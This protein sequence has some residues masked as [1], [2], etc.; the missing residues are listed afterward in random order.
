MKQLAE[1]EAVL[2]LDAV[3]RPGH[4]IGAAGR[5]E[6]VVVQL[7]SAERVENLDGVRDVERVGRRQVRVAEV[8]VAE[9]AAQQLEVEAPD[10]DAGL[11]IRRRDAA[12]CPAIR[13]PNRCPCSCRNRRARCR[14]QKTSIKWAP[15]IH[16]LRKTAP[17]VPVRHE[18][19]LL[20]DGTGVRFPGGQVGV[21][22][23]RADPRRRV[24]RD[25]LQLAA[26]PALGLERPVV[27][28]LVERDGRARD[29]RAAEQV[30]LVPASVVAA[31]GPVPVRVRA[32]NDGQAG[33]LVDELR[34]RHADERLVDA[35]VGFQ[36]PIT[37]VGDVVRRD[38]DGGLHAVIAVVEVQL[39]PRARP[40]CSCSASRCSSRPAPAA[41]SGAACPRRSWNQWRGSC[42][43][44]GP[45]EKRS[46][47]RK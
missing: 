1:A 23:G 16:C 32:G 35:E 45:H 5:A 24:E 13:R 39:G 6:V 12:S 17:S 9:H 40:C 47:A 25:R 26:E 8:A 44:C 10:R 38:L 28:V 14:W 20:R 30:R 33:V 43:V 34:V 3:D 46:G 21:G 18:R 27:H 15:R 41:A 36:P 42:V 2:E 11:G 29:V 19:R 4:R 7:P 37:G 31:G 22:V